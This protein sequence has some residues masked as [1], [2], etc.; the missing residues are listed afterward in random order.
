ML[1]V[2]RFDASVDVR[3]AVLPSKL[4]K[5]PGSHPDLA[6]AVCVL[7]FELF[8]VLFFGAMPCNL[9]NLSSMKYDLPIG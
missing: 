1:V 3:D 2:A 9:R 6:A 7:S 5:M 8:A 4:P